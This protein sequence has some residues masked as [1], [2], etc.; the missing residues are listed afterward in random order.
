MIQ[1]HTA[2]AIKTYCLAII[3]AASGITGFNLAQWDL[4][5]GIIFKLLGCISTLLIIIINWSSLIK[6]IKGSNIFKKK[7]QP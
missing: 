3:A 5:L 4:I 1:D 6:M 2:L 7:K